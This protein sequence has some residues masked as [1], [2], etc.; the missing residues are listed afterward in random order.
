MSAS[1]VSYWNV[2]IYINYLY[3]IIQNLHDCKVVQNRETR[4]FKEIG[5]WKVE[6]RKK[7]NPIT[8]DI[9]LHVV[10]FL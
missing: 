2:I 6:V 5:T 9:N 7:V 1:R 10:F 8:R 4:L 3:Y